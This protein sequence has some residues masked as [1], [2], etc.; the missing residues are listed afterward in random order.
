MATIDWA[1]LNLTDAFAVE[2][3]PEPEQLPRYSHI[4]TA[5]ANSP[6]AIEASKWATIVDLLA[7]R[8]SGARLDPDQI[9]A[10]LGAAGSSPPRSPQAVGSVAVLPLRGTLIPRADMMSE[11]SGATGLEGWTKRF[12]AA[13]ADPN[14]GAIVLDVDSPGGSVFGVDEAATAVF[15][16]R[17][18]KHIVAVANLE[19][20]SAAYYIA[21]Q[22]DEL[23]VTPS[24]WVGSIGVF[25]AHQDLS[26]ALE[27]AGIKTTLISAGKFKT[28]SSPFEPLGADARA[29][30]QAR[31][32]EFYGMFVKAVARGRGVSTTAVRNGFGQGRMELA[33]SAV[34]LGMAD[35]VATFDQT[36]ERVARGKRLGARADSPAFEPSAAELDMIDL[37][38]DVAE[39][40]SQAWG[41]SLDMRRRRMRR[42]ALA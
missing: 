12:K 35:L 25:G 20:G 5:V 38:A 32:D 21:S 42:Q 16:A 4:L 30:M 9:K 27:K 11:M 24:G 23:V 37:E 41:A 1:D 22:A 26:A 15:E 17:G 29:A 39:A 2:Q 28:E 6:W 8:A 36:V 18:S 14:V 19:A 3:P 10:R 33:S 31:V 34:A 13:V 40:V 7:L